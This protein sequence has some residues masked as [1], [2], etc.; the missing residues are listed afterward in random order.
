KMA[1][2]SRK[3]RGIGGIGKRQGAKSAVFTPLVIL[4]RSVEMVLLRYY[5]VWPAVE[6]LAGSKPSRA[7]RRGNRGSLRS[8]SAKG[9][10]RRYTRYSQRSAK[11]LSNQENASS[12]RFRPV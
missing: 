11:A 5:G 1:A 7:N 2:T 6:G 12:L 9:S 3:V 8:G 4:C 10:V